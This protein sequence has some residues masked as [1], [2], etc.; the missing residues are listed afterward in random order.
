[1]RRY[2][3][4]WAA[5]EPF[6]KRLVFVGGCMYGVFLLIGLAV[7]VVFKNGSMLVA[8]LFSVGILGA[9]WGL[10]SAA[11]RLFPDQDVNSRK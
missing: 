11:D 3:R 7:A 6:D 9:A 10:W 8:A 2:L 1:M 4:R 5:L